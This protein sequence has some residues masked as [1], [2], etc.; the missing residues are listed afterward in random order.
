MEHAQR[1][2]DGKTAAEYLLRAKL[3]K[4]LLCRLHGAMM[5]LFPLLI[6]AS[7]LP[8]IAAADSAQW[9]DCRTCHRVVA[10]NGAILAEGGRSAPNLFGIANRPLAADQGFAFYSADLRAAAATG[11]RWSEDNF[12]AYMANPN[13]FLRAVT[14]NDNAQSD[15]HVDLRAGARDMFRWLN[16]FSQ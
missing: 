7:V 16:A 14:G 1:I 6:A 5:K 3:P 15:M 13:Q 4:T 10:P 2:C 9:R 8:G 11:A 12:V